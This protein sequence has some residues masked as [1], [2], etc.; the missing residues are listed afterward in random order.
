MLSEG[1]TPAVKVAGRYGYDL[2]EVGAISAQPALG[3]NLWDVGLWDQALWAGSFATEQ[4]VSGAA[5]M[6]ADA[7]IAFGLTATARTVVV[8]FDVAFTTGGML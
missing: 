6:G 3:S 2:S 1:A 8:G 7:A 4:P 5:G